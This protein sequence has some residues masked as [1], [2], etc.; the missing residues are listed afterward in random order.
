MKGFSK[1]ALLFGL[2]GGLMTYFI[3]PVQ[4]SR[5]R[6]LSPTEK[7]E[8]ALTVNYYKSHCGTVTE[9]IEEH[10]KT[11]ARESGGGH[12]GRLRC[13]VATSPSGDWLADVV[14]LHGRALAQAPLSGQRRPVRIA[15][16]DLHLNLVF[17]GQSCFSSR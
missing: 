15:P 5:K 11:Y 12:L 7:A 8:Y 13:H 17:F 2:L 16:P 4:F 14:P 9:E 10:A 6:T 3:L 1:I